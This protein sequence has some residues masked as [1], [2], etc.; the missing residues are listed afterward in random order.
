[1]VSNDRR[2]K[3]NTY[4]NYSQTDINDVF[5]TLFTYTSFTSELIFLIIC[6]VFECKKSSLAINKL[7]YRKLKQFL[8]LFSC[9]E[10]INE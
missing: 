6:N 1:M 10:K 2:N 3:M 5:I 8:T 9:G 4:F 7:Q